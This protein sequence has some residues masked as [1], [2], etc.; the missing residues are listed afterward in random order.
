MNIIQININI[1]EFKNQDKT[2]LL[3]IFIEYHKN[4]HFMQLYMLIYIYGILLK[5]SKIDIQKFH[6]FRLTY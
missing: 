6:Q 2:K 1:N 5:N 3:K 4:F